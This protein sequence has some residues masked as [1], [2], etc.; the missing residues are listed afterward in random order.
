MAKLILGKTPK[1]FK[2]FPVKFT[3]PDGEEDQIVV[4]F[5]YK[6]RSEFATFLNALFQAAPDAPPA[7]TADDKIDF[8]ELFKKGGDKTVAHLSQIIEGWDL[9]DE[10]TPATLATMHD[11]APAAAAAMTS[12]YSAA[13]TEGRLGN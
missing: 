4:T 8:V 5:K 6:T 11:Q 9:S 1:N 13:C 7:A 2:P 12:A 10:I 3:L